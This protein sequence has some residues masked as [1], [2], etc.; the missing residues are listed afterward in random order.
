MT[1]TKVSIKPRRVSLTANGVLTDFDFDFKIFAE[2]QVTVYLL[3]TDDVATLQTITTDYTVTFDSEAE[4]GTITFLSPPTDQYTVL[5]ISNVDY[6]QAT[7]I[8]KGG[9]FS[10]PVVEKAYDLLAIQ[11]QQLRGGLDRAVTLSDT[12]PL[13]SLT[14]P[15]PDAGKA[16][17]WNATADGLENSIDDFNDIVTNA[18]AA[19]TAAEAAQT[20]AE[21]AETNAETSETNAAA[22]E[23]CAEN[24]AQ[25]AEDSPILVGCGGDGATDFSALHWAN[26]AAAIAATINLPAI[27]AGDV[28]KILEVNVAEN[29]YDLVAPGGSELTL[30]VNQATHGFSVNDWVYH[31]GTIYALADASAAG[32]AESV[33]VVSAV[34]G[35]DDFTIQFGGRITGLSGLTAGALHYIS[36]TAGAITNVI[37]VTVGAVEKPVLIADSTTSGFIFN[38]RSSVIGSGV[39]ATDLNLAGQALGDKI[40]F[41]GT[42]WVAAGVNASEN[43]HQFSFTRDMTLTADSVHTGF[44]FRP[45][46]IFFTATRTPAVAGTGTIGIGAGTSPSFGNTITNQHVRSANTWGNNGYMMVEDLPG[47]G[48]YYA[49]NIRTMDTDGCTIQYTRA[50]ACTGTLQIFG[51]AIR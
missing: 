44:Q 33:G 40:Y 3:D 16:W 31:N 9:G 38:Q 47:G 34:A 5:M 14:V 15:T 49:M 19:Q 42:N 46:W 20:A 1:V 50:G 17:L 35:A 4:T 45:S 36:E 30:A 7:D 32:T 18:E 41:D 48:S 23:G 28:G 2:G 21:T 10:E 13:T 43:I 25:K 37:P 26:K 22:S 6:E 24:W 51:L 8:P 12:S 39:V 11:I 29:G 27:Q